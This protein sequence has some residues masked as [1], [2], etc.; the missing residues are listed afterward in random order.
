MKNPQQ[1]K[2]NSG[3]GVD[4]SLM[5]LC[6]LLLAVSLYFFFQNDGLQS[7]PR[8]EMSTIGQ[9]SNTHND[10]RRRINSGFSWSTIG[11]SEKIYEGDSIF[12]G[13]D[14]DAS[15]VLE[16]GAQLHVDPQSMV[17][18]K[19]Q[20]SGLR[21]DLQY[22]SMV[23][24]V[25]KDNPLVISQNGHLQEISGADAEIRIESS[26]TDHKTTIQV[27]RGEVQMKAVENVVKAKLHP[28]PQRVQTIKLNQ[29]LNLEAEKAPTI[30][31]IA[32][33]L[34]APQ[35][36]KV[37]WLG[38]G[39]PVL[40]TW[41]LTGSD[42]NGENTAR[43]STANGF[44]IEFSRD[45]DFV[46]PFF[47]ANSK[48]PAFQLPEG[49]R[50]QGEFFWRVEPTGTKKNDRK[51]ELPSAPNRLTLYADLPPT[52]VFPADHQAF[53]LPA[54][55]NTA[56]ADSGKALSMS[57][58]DQ[59]GS[60]EFD[61]QIAR[62]AEFKNTIIGKR[63]GTLSFQTPRLDAGSY[64]WRIRG[65]NPQRKTPPWSHTM[66]FTIEEDAKPPLAPRLVKTKI[67]YEIPLAVLKVAPA[68]VSVRGHGVLPTGLTPFAWNA[69][70]D[71][72]GYEV[73]LADNEGFVNSIKQTL[74]GEQSFA[75]Q[76][77][78][79]GS[80][81]MRVRAKGKKG[82]V[83]E[84]SEI[85]RLDVTLPAPVLV[86]VIPETAMYKTPAEL[87]SG[88][89][90]FNLSWS[91]RPF[92]ESYEL[93]WGTSAEFDKSKKFRLKSTERA[94]K[95]TNPLDYAARVRA[96]GPDGIPL[97][98]YSAVQIASF[99]KELL[100]PPPPPVLAAKPPTP[101]VSVKAPS[102][103]PASISPDV[104]SSSTGIRGPIL[105]DPK[106]SSSYVTLEDSLSFVNFRWK[107]IAQAQGYELQIGQDA[108]FTKIIETLHPNGTSIT[109]KKELPEGKV[110]WRV[111]AK[112]KKGPTEWSDVFNINVLYE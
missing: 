32:V 25:T 24:K 26:E 103:A 51:I 52:P 109:L 80:L 111:R 9:I 65:L 18:V 16:N 23:G 99:K 73:E 84:S 66:L 59:S 72:Q 102:P 67:D 33:Q 79:P 89:H 105:Q 70:V 2:P 11:G 96:L 4:V 68:N 8:K 48:T 17:V 100:P 94:I 54:A 45:K 56:P 76:E 82:L 44:R 14:S 95:V 101:P 7:G 104:L 6:L 35:N 50:P 112:L 28:A 63:L 71:A 93:D 34:I 98:D 43:T 30:Q 21:L 74:N 53:A 87:Q 57:W 3:L 81:F 62:D 39:E 69:V 97:S 85:G 77:V 107:P 36:S 110:F 91:A 20:G 75:P 41:K 49:S 37:L 31:T 5:T 10:V 86:A 29:V 64:Y 42:V 12:T 27:V 106:P 58:E 47:T 60:N 83:S 19:T 88:S 55:T 1:D 15:V 78:K 92:A 61:L 13:E 90:V 38:V 40:M 108:D 22:G 46:K